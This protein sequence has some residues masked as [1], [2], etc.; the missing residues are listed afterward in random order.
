MSK[1]KSQIISTILIILVAVLGS[2]FVNLGMEWFN[3]L[4]TPSQWLPNFIIP[5]VW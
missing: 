2:V 4:T 3:S 1:A 5:I